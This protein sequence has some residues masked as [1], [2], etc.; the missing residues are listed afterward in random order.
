MEKT[1]KEKP[2]KRTFVA[3]VGLD[4]MA[5]SKPKRLEAGKRADDIPARSVN[6]LL[7]QGLIKEVK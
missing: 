4:Y 6:W 2:G 3:L 1:E 5:G 7:E